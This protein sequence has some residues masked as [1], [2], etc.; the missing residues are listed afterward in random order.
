[1][2]NRT[3]PG[4]E[5]DDGRQAPVSP[6]IVILVEPQLGENIGQAARAMANFG[7]QELR[8]VAPRDG[9]PNEKALANAAGASLIVENAQIFS[10]VEDAIADLHYLVATT[11][12][13]REMLKP[14]ATPESAA[15]EF[16]A[17]TARGERCGILFGRER[18]GLENDEVSLADTIVIAPVDPAFASL[19][20]AQA[21]LLLGYE[22]RKATGG[23]SLGRAT[24]CDG[25]AREGL[26]LNRC[27]PA[28]RDELLHFFAHL[29]TELTEGGF[30]KTDAKRSSM[31]RNIRNIFLRASLTSQEIS[32]LRGIIRALTRL[33]R[34]RNRVE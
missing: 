27:N 13:I 19:N 32:T 29:E 31:V 7:L 12:R 6:P 26:A 18:S 16:S 3:P 25:P 24:P 5:T 1:M 14:V 2:E 11:A 10:T 33:R 17:R 9:W 22:W 28:T 34:L 4:A 15:R 8:L 30:F 23:A 21:V 20:L